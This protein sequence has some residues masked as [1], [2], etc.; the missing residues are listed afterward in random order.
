MRLYGSSGNAF[1]C[2]HVSPKRP[3]R[4]EILPHGNYQA[5]VALPAAESDREFARRLRKGTGADANASGAVRLAG[6]INFKERYA[7]D[8]PPRPARPQR[9]GPSHQPRPA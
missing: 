4:K 3:A 9:A 6:S 5:W 2:V 1:G 7:P 8:F